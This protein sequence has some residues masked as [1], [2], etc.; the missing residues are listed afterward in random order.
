MENKPDDWSV[1]D[2]LWWGL[3]NGTIDPHK[4]SSEEWSW[5]LIEEM[6][7]GDTPAAKSA[8]K[9]L[10]KRTLKKL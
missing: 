2:D 7:V 4:D 1:E 6:A 8:R 3:I 9:A 10:L 5:K